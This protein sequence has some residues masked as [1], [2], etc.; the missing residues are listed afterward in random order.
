ML[1]AERPIL[2]RILSC[3]VLAPD[4][5]R[6]DD[7]AGEHEGVGDLTVNTSSVDQFVGTKFRERLA[8]SAAESLQGF[9]L[10]AFYVHFTTRR[11]RRGACPGISVGSRAETGKESVQC[12]GSGRT[13]R[14]I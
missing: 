8:E 14:R 10:A 9:A 4:V 11:G 1:E 2:V 6:L 3:V 13:G 7:E 12:A 5:P